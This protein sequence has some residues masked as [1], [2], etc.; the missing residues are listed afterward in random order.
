MVT[1]ANGIEAVGRRRSSIPKTA[2]TTLSHRNVVARLNCRAAPRRHRHSLW[3]PGTTMSEASTEDYVHLFEWLT[4]PA[5][6]RDLVEATNPSRVLHVGSGSSI[7]AEHL[8]ESFPSII[9]ECVNVDVDQE[10][11]DGMRNRWRGLHENDN[12]LDRLTFLHAD[13]GGRNAL[14]QFGDGYFDLII[15]KSTLDCLLCSEHAATGLLTHVYRLLAVSGTY[16]LVS[17]HDVNFVRPLLDLPG[18]EWDIEHSVMTRQVEDLVS[19]RRAHNNLTH[20][21]EANPIS[22]VPS[23]AL[24]SCG[25]PLN[26]FRCKKRSNNRLDFDRVHEHILA[27]NN[28]WYKNENPIMTSRRLQDLQ[29][30]FGDRE[31]LNLVEA[32]D[33]LFTEAEREDLSYDLFMEDWNAFVGSKPEIEKDSISLHTAVAF[34]KEMQ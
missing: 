29:N 10:T 33:A 34:L 4:S 13:L 2:T 9:T 11:L 5:S 14:D 8:V 26:V 21:A 16:L 18:A 15:D 31:A 32:Y 28:H 30:A 22:R 3:P 25:R 23:D 17:F 1:A 7:L 24:E 20:Q 6:L 27:T 19:T 12:L